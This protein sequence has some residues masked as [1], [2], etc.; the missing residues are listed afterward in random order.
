VYAVSVGSLSRGLTGIHV[1]FTY[2]TTLVVP[3]L[4]FFKG[5]VKTAEPTVSP[6]ENLYLLLSPLWPPLED[7][8]S[9]GYQLE[10]LEN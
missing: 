3:S 6:A 7:I 5:C 4:F 2:A 1:F 8:L 9:Q 10:K